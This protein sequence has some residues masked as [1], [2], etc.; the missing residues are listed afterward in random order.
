MADATDDAW[1]GLWVTQQA[2][3]LTGAIWVQRLPMKFAQLWLPKAEGPKVD[4]L[5][6]AAHQWVK[7]QDIRLCHVVLSPEATFSETVLLDHG[8]QRLAC[9]QHLIGSSDQR[10]WVK[11]PASLSLMAFNE[12]SNAEQLALLAAVGHDSLDSRALREILSVQEL[13]AGFYQQDPQAPQHWYAVGYR[14]VIVGVLLLAPH[15][16]T[17]RWELM[18]MGLKPE[19]RGQGLGRALLNKAL[20]LAQQAGAR[21]V[22]LAVDAVNLPAKRLYQQAGFMRYTQQRLFAWKGNADRR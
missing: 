10:L 2:G 6:R 11:Q 19:W 1:Q 16:A 13:L 3:Q 15:A 20:Y 5:L 12:L 21:E 22:T 14:G 9:L 8:M 18:L 4:T 17:G 7:K